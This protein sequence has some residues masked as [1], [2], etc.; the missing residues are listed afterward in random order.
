MKTRAAAPARLPWRRF[1]RVG[2]VSRSIDMAL[3]FC[4]ARLAAAGF[5][6]VRKRAM[7][8]EAKAESRMTLPRDQNLKLTLARTSWITR[9]EE[10]CSVFAPPPASVIAPSA[11]VFGKAA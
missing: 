1:F 3:P 6:R 8:D 4:C 10:P 2:L 9:S 11:L 7:K 5:R